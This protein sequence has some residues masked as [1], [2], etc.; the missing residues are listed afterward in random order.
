MRISERTNS[1][2]KPLKWIENHEKGQVGWVKLESFTTAYT[3]AKN[4]K[5]VKVMLDER[6]Y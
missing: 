3:A 6:V 2:V 1:G 5:L 4:E